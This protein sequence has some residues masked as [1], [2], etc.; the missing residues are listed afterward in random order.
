[1]KRP[2]DPLYPF[3]VNT[4]RFGEGTFDIHVRLLENGEQTAATRVTATFTGT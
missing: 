3:E 2:R 1:M 4:R